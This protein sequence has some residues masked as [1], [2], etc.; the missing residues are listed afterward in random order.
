MKNKYPHLF[1]PLTIRNITFR[2]RIFSV[3]ID[4]PHCGGGENP[5]AQTIEFFRRRAAS[6]CAEVT[7]GGGLLKKSMAFNPPPVYNLE[8]YETMTTYTEL[9]NAIK[10]EGAVASME[11]MAGNIKVKA[12]EGEKTMWSD[13]GVN[14]ITLPEMEQLVHDYADAAAFA[15]QAG[16]QMVLVHFGHGGF[17]T[18]VLSPRANRRTDEFGGSAANRARLPKM[19]LK[20]IRERIGDDML[21]E[22]RISTAELVDGGTTVEDSIVFLKEV[23]DIIDIAH[24]SVGLHEVPALCARLHPSTYFEQGCNLFAAEAVKKAVKIPVLT[25]GGYSEPE[26]MERILAEGKADIIGVN[27]SMLADMDY[28][29]KIRR[30]KEREIRPCVR[31]LECHAMVE[32]HYLMCAINPEAGREFRTLPIT[33]TAEP[34]DVMVIG[35]GVGGMQAAITAAEKG[36][37]VTIYEKSGRLGGVMNFVDY[38]DIKRDTKRLMDYFRNRVEDLGIRVEL[39]YEMTPEKAEVLDPYAIIVAI[40]ADVIVPGIKGIEKAMHVLEGYE[41]TAL[42]GDSIVIVGGGLAGMEAGLH[43]GKLGKKVTV[44][45]MGDDYARDGNKRIRGSLADFA[46]KYGLNVMLNTKCVEITDEGVVTDR[47]ETLKADNV[48]Y[49]VGMRARNAQAQAYAPYA[50]DFAIIGD[51][52]TPGKMQQAI[53]GGYFAA[54]N[55]D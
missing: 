25:L 5:T 15:K 18:Q 50:Y 49:G 20:G 41:K 40:G 26:L 30:D 44:V 47:G 33:K 6:G 16:F 38:D 10:N 1:A 12:L 11:L 21:I 45:E 46:E 43:F 3:P 51:C 37:N 2:N 55:I 22:L 23:E 34:K 13:N 42:L 7:V 8:N 39:N 28:V 31:C 19:I 17:L 48:L 36:H 9:A 35:G 52:K 4:F 14:Q 24:C 54:R 27:R 29:S 53:Y 32:H